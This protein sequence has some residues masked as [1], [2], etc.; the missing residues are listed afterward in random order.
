MKNM[1]TS[2]NTM[3]IAVLAINFLIG[4]LSASAKNKVKEG[5]VMA[6]ISLI[7]KKSNPV[8]QRRLAVFDLGK[9]AAGGNMRAMQ[10]LV[11]NISLRLP[12]N[13]IKGDEDRLKETPCW[14]ALETYCRGQETVS[15]CILAELDRD[16]SDQN[17]AKL[18]HVL[19]RVEGRKAALKRIAKEIKG[20]HKAKVTANL[21]RIE[22]RLKR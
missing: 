18:A 9:Q 11:T 14:F 16:Y 6:T 12:M 7:D 19:E 8:E 1:K 22:E 15:N 4:T 17:L 20:K 3:V 10:Y 2:L 13:T 21:K 5:N